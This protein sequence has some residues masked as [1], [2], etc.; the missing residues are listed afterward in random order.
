MQGPRATDDV[1][2]AAPRPPAPESETPDDPA[3]DK[4]TGAVETEQ[5]VA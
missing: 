3:T 4:A 5:E 1:M 2:K